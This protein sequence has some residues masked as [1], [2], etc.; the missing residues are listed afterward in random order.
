MPYKD[1]EKQ[2]AALKDFYSKNSRA[3][4][5]RNN[6]RR[7]ELKIWFKEYIKD[8]KCQRCP[9]DHY[10]CIDWHHID[11]TTKRDTVSALL[12]QMRNKAIIIAELEKCIPLCANCH[13]KLHAEELLNENVV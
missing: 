5:D 8:A 2:K 3:Y 1:P 13:R 6:K 7:K 12:T 9:E 4:K 11:R 10:S